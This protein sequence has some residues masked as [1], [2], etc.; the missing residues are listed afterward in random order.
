[1][2]PELINDPVV[3]SIA[4]AIAYA[5]NGGAPNVKNPSKGKTGEMKSIY[6]FTPATWKNYSKEI[7]GQVVPMNEDTETAVV[8]HKVKTWLDEDN[9]KGI[10]M[11]LAVKRIASRWNAGSGEPDAHDGTFKMTTKTHKAGDPSKGLLK[12]F[13]N[14][15]YDVPG[16]ANKVKGYADQFMS[17][18]SQNKVAQA[19]Q[20]PQGMTP[21]VAQGKMKFLKDRLDQLLSSAVPH[22][23]AMEKPDQPTS[24]NMPLMQPNAPKPEEVKTPNTQNMGLLGK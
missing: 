14:T 20:N 13:N 1:M 16:Y 10:P 11:D 19:P 17:E 6:Q 8:M 3:R 4:K 9:K 21:E 15:P 24:S 2:N 22:A 23:S 12:Q 18:H 5:E 7:F